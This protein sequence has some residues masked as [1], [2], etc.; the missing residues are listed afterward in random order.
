MANASKNT[1]KTTTKTE[2]T[3]VGTSAV[4]NTVEKVEEIKET[5]IATQNEVVKPL[6]DDDEITVVSLIPNVTYKDFKNGDYYEW[7]EVGHEEIMTF[8]V[9]KDMN[10]NYKTYLKDMWVKPLDQRVIDKFGLTK[11]YLNYEYLMDENSYTRKD[12]SEIVQKL[13]E[14]PS[15]IKNT[16]INKI[17]SLVSE[18]KVA[19]VKIIK[20]LEKTFDV[21]LIELLD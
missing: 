2:A 15:G 10:R 14:L 4:V 18:G 8:A 20:E 6:E 1:N 13:S 7:Q 9:L 11:S 3:T 16:I 12:I 17:K 19:D 21:D 5:K